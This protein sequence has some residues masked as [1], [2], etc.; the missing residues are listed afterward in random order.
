MNNSATWFDLNNYHNDLTLEEWSYEI[1]VRSNYYTHASFFDDAKFR[2]ASGKGP[3]NKML[4]WSNGLPA[5]TENYKKFLTDRTFFSVHF[6]Q[7]KED[8]L[9]EKARPAIEIFDIQDIFPSQLINELPDQINKDEIESHLFYWCENSAPI[10]INLEK[11][12]NDLVAE[13]KRYLK[14]RRQEQKE[15]Y[16]LNGNITGKIHEWQSFRLLELFDLLFWR[17]AFDRSLTYTQIGHLV[18]PDDHIE[19]EQRVRKKGI[20]LIEKAF[21]VEMAKAIYMEHMKTVQK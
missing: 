2:I 21:S 11:S 8:W 6:L 18:W 14:D 3:I 12:D 7:R 4:A 9:K 19:I 1:W 15:F 17:E 5:S 13:F 10:G 20:P 16:S